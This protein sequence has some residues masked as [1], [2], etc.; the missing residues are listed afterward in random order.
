[1][2]NSFS[3]QEHSNL[4]RK[5]KSKNLIKLVRRSPNG[6]IYFYLKFAEGKKKRLKQ[7]GKETTI[8]RTPVCYNKG[9]KIER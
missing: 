8:H 2:F 9:A 3:S 4:K 6:F 7:K 1:M 5:I